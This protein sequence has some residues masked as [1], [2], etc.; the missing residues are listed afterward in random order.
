MRRP[1]V[2]R[3][4]VPNNRRACHTICPNAQE[5]RFYQFNSPKVEFTI[6][7]QEARCRMINVYPSI[8]QYFSNTKGI[9]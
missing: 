3:Y 9:S 1:L 5:M 2:S 4:K 6:D 8:G 7:V